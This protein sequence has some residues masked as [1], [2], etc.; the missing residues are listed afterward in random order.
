MWYS[1]YHIICD[2]VIICFIE[3]YKTRSTCN[4]GDLLFWGGDVCEWYLRYLQQLEVGEGKVYILTA[5]TPERFRCSWSKQIPWG[6]SS[7][8]KCLVI[9]E[10]ATNFQTYSHD[11]G[12]A[13]SGYRVGSCLHKV[14]P[15]KEAP[16]SPLGSQRV[17]LKYCKGPS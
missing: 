16:R 3:H 2:I 1:L 6:N 9:W 10:T 11:L 17:V 4:S 15:W 7:K 12:K 8:K 5:P 13:D 14:P